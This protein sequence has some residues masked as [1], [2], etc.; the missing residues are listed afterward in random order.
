LDVAAEAGKDFAGAS[1]ASQQTASP[2]D[3][4]RVRETVHLS[5]EDGLTWQV[6]RLLR[7]GPSAYS[8]LA[9]LRI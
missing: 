6:S 7:D 9:V 5:D 2:P 8:S 3:V 1:A 4:R